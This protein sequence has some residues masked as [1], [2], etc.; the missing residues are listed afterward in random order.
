MTMKNKKYNINSS[1]VQNKINPWVVTGFSDGESSF[2][3]SITQ[4]SDNNKW[5]VSAIFSITL[6]IKELPL[7]L[8]IQEDF[9]GV[10]SIILN[11]KNNKVIY[12]ITKLDDLIIVIPHF[13]SLLKNIKWIISK[14]PPKDFNPSSFPPSDLENILN[15]LLIVILFFIIY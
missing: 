13:T 11:K 14:T 10:G 15:V 9:Q 4:R 12:R 2:I 1:G 3:I 7:L 8:S 6:H 5:K